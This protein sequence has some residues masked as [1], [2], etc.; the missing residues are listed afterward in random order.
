VALYD[1]LL[2]ARKAIENWLVIVDPNDPATDLGAYG[3]MD[4]QRKRL[5]Q[6]LVT[7]ENEDLTGALKNLETDAK[8]LNDDANEIMGISTS[9]DDV[10]TVVSAVDDIVA[11][12]KQLFPALFPLA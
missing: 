7:I 6:A 2:N 9:F 1:T 5:S 10:A 4:A 3:K 12:L 11:I 8:S